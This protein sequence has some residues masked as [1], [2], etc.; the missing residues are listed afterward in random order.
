MLCVIYICL[1]VWTKRILPIYLTTI[2]FNQLYRGTMLY[3]NMITFCNFLIVPI[4]AMRTY[5]VNVIIEIQ[6]KVG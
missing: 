1:W 2:C 3:F 4:S 6:K 5:N